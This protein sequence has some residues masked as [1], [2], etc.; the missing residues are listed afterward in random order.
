MQSTSTSKTLHS[1]RNSPKKS[2]N[3]E[4]ESVV[5][6][7]T[8]TS[9]TKHNTPVESPR[10]LASSKKQTEASTK[11]TECDDTSKLES[12][13]RHEN[14]PNDANVEQIISRSDFTQSKDSIVSKSPLKNAKDADVTISDTSLNSS[15]KISRLHEKANNLELLTNDVIPVKSKTSEVCGVEQSSHEKERAYRCHLCDASFKNDELLLKHMAMNLYKSCAVVNPTSSNASKCMEAS[16]ETITNKKHSQNLEKSKLS[17]LQQQCSVN[18]E[19]SS[20]QLDKSV[21]DSDME[22]PPS[23]SSSSSRGSKTRREHFRISQRKT[24]TRSTAKS[25]SDFNLDSSNREKMLES[26][27]RSINMKLKRATCKI[28]LQVFD[29]QAQLLQHMFKHF[30][31]DLRNMYTSIENKLDSE[32]QKP[33]E[34]NNQ[35]SDDLTENSIEAAVGETV[36]V[37][38]NNINEQEKNLPENTNESSAD[39][40]SVV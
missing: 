39:R 40:K 30:A 2:I 27:N 13:I 18:S 12:F 33:N 5:T 23:S 19:S 10:K 31:N 22:I 4:C 17:T 6:P 24:K 11:P 32:N 8:S 14:L 37:A 9:S 36:E 1:L 16:N 29:T 26:K 35:V 21:I 7:S 28:C 15:K 25:K 3:A 34:N 38:E 20:R